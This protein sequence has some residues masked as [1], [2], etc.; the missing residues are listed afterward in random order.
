M[1][2]SKYWMSTSKTLFIRLGHQGTKS[3][4]RKNQDFRLKTLTICINLILIRLKSLFGS[5]DIGNLSKLRII[6]SNTCTVY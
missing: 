6:W 3:I 2:F 5:L 4:T 1:F